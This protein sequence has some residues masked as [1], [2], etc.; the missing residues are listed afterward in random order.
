LYEL[1]ACPKSQLVSA[2]ILN[3][4]AGISP[5][6]YSLKTNCYKDFPG[7]GRESFVATAR[8]NKN[9]NIIH[10]Q[11]TPITTGISRGLLKITTLTKFLVVLICLI[12]FARSA[13]AQANV[14]LTWNSISN[15]LVAGFKIYYGGVSG[16][17]T[18]ETDAGKATHVTI[19]NL[20]NGSTYY[21]ASTTYSAAGAES[22]MSGE[23][24]YI[25]PSPAPVAHLL[26][27]PAKQFILTVTGLT[28][29]AYNV[30]ASQNL[31]TWAV[32]GS[33]TVGT[34]GSGTFTDAN[35]VNY[36]S[37]YYRIN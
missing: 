17:Y 6:P 29:H 12:A 35:A 20:V 21:F 7:N 36:S 8:S 34:S 1:L 30:L 19:S 11:K 24:S 15:P 25:V 23:T 13:Q 9:M 28:N 16:V 14:T 31:T 22:A 18:N 33:V 4:L 10:E 5:A 32:I 37:R 26:V 3:C 27:T 2:G